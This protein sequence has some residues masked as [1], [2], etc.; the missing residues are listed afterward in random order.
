MLPTLTVAKNITVSGTV[1]RSEDNEP[2][3]GVSVLVEGTTRGTITDIDGRFTIEAEKGQT[4]EF[5][6][7]GYATVKEKVVGNTMQIKL[8]ED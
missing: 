2:L 8:H 7:V 5:S 4:I 1:L 3:I 6:Y